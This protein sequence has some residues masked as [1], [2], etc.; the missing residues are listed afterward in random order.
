MNFTDKQLKWIHKPCEYS[1]NNNEIVVITSPYT[2]LWQKTYYKFINDNAPLLQTRTNDKYFSFIV[3]V[4]SNSHSRFDQCGIVI[5]LD[6]EN[7]VKA[8]I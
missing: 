3:K 2:D 7:W 1:I 8:S 6:S 4:S 5:Y